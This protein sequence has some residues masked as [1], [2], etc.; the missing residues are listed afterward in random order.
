MPVPV[1]PHHKQVAHPVIKHPYPGDAEHRPS[2]FQHITHSLPLPPRGPPPSFASRE[3][4]ISSLPDWRR[5]KQRCIWEDDISRY[6]ELGRSS[7]PQG[8]AVA[9][10]A[11]AIKGAPAQ[12]CIPPISTLVASADQASR[13]RFAGAYPSVVEEEDDMM[14]PSELDEWH[15]DVESSSD[16]N[17]EMDESPEARHTGYSSAQQRSRYDR[18]MEESVHRTSYE[19]G[20]FTPLCEVS[21]DVT[22]N[23]PASSPIGPATPFAEYVDRAVADAQNVVYDNQSHIPDIVS[24]HR[25]DYA[26]DY[27]GAQCYQCQHN[28]G[29]VPQPIQPPPA[30]EP[31]STPSANT[32]Y[33]KLAEP[34]ADWMASFVW[35]VC[36]TGMH[37][38]PQY[39]QP[40]A[41]MKQYPTAP[42]PG[43]A[44]QIH[45]L[46]MSTLLQPSAIFLAIWYI[47]RLPVYFG[48][49]AISHPAHLKEIR[50]RE[51]LF[52]DA[53]MLVDRSSAEAYAPFRLFVLGC[54]FANKWLD[55][56][57]FSNKTWHSVSS[58]PIQVIN[59]LESLALDIFNYD[60][61]ISPVEWSQWLEKIHT[62]HLSLSSAAFPQPISRPSSSPHTIVRKAIESL[63]EAGIASQQ[64]PGQPVFLGTEERQRASEALY[65]GDHVDMLEI[66]L[67]EDGPLREEYLPRR[68]VSGAS[69]TRYV[70]SQERVVEPERMLPPPARWSPQGD[71]PLMHRR[72]QS[73]YM[74]PQP[75][76]QLPPAP[77]A[78]MAYQE[79]AQ[80]PRGWPWGPSP[81]HLTRMPALVHP[82]QPAYG[83]GYVAPPSHARSHSLSYHASTAGLSQSHYRTY[84]QSRYDG[85]GDVRF[86]EPHYVP[87]P[88]PPVEWSHFDRTTYSAAYER[89]VEFLHRIPLKV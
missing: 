27:C 51:E 77:V 16:M 89:P 43:L 59:R 36:T 75:V 22:G 40:L 73:Q 46:F 50:F 10:N 39:A 52:G 25:Y 34:L 31:I 79:M 61:S 20:M 33:K 64:N 54:M 17:Y 88:P 24:R 86:P 14:S 15:N 74:A 70:R 83:Y 9:G 44:Q 3:E 1:P 12:A 35:K 37:L 13:H 6:N 30:P 69:S 11:A 47:T 42:P 55:D 82:Q 2:V 48:P 71:E 87:P 62:Y 57:T 85:Y 76:M 63:T 72:V 8:L 53:R 4:W 28:Y 41:Y 32:D 18:G 21:P 68:R 45:S 38:Q 60:L 23:D 26:E 49:T 58:V 78:P 19:R 67:D 80:P 5:N 84:S 29:Q 81:E 65:G 7:F 66:D 56:H